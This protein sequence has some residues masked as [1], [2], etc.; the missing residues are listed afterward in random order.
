MQEFKVTI[1]Y[2][3]TTVPPGQ[4]NETLSVYK[5]LK[6]KIKKKINLTILKFKTCVHQRTL[7]NRVKR[8]PTEWENIFMCPISGK[9][10]IF[11][12]HDE[13][14]QLTDRKRNPTKKMNE[15]FE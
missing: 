1:S 14:L 7:A 9:R 15:G 5:F 2:D 4:Q 13:L 8:R 6:R 11:R 12:I 3:C 10:L